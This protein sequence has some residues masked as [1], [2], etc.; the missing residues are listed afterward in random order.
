MANSLLVRFPKELLHQICSNL[1]CPSALD[2]L[3]VCRYVKH[4]C[5]DWTV[6]REIARQ[7]IENQ[8][9]GINV[10]NTGTADIWK[11]YIVAATKA[12]SSQGS[13][14]IEDLDWL[15]QLSALAYP[16]ALKASA[17]LD[18]LFNSTLSSSILTQAIPFAYNQVG[19]SGTNDCSLRTWRLAHAASFFHS[20]YH[21]SLPASKVW[22]TE[23][24]ESVPWT[25]M[26]D[27]NRESEEE[28]QEMQVL[29]QHTFANRA[30]GFF[31]QIL[32]S[33]HASSSAIGLSEPP[34]ATTIPFTRM[35]EL[36]PPFTSRSLES[37][38]KSH[39]P[40]MADPQFFVEGDW[41]G[42]TSTGGRFA[43]PYFGVGGPHLDGFADQER[44]T[45][46]PFGDFPWGRVFEGVVRFEVLEEEEEEADDDIYRLRSNNYHSTGALHELHITV[47]R[48]TGQLEI[49]HWHPLREIG[50]SVQLM[51]SLLPLA[52]CLSFVQRA[53]GCGFGRRVGLVNILVFFE[54]P[55]LTIYFQRIIKRVPQTFL[56]N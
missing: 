32:R 41:A 36:P 55:V 14:G 45:S 22:S 30:V 54:Y 50:I 51:V 18:E 11:R 39:L 43:R 8:V 23:S 46:T 35:M 21:L 48:R 24:L 49:V 29:M 9:R 56:T 16:G 33:T 19:I 5:D 53:R 38:S 27:R 2:F 1:S 47:N 31:C 26:E 3:L 12:T 7:C 52:L 17:F 6:W 13:W 4:S 20:V 40:V 28:Y 10:P 34:L 15:P 44:G 25:S 42:Y 37:L